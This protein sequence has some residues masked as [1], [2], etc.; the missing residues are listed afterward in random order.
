MRKAA[1]YVAI[2]MSIAVLFLATSGATTAYAGGGN[3]GSPPGN[4]GVVKVISDPGDS[5]NDPDNDPHVCL[6]HLYGFNFDANSSGTWHIDPW[7]PDGGPLTAEQRDGTWKAFKGGDKSKDWQFNAYPRQP[8]P[9]GH[10][11]LTVKQTNGMTPGGDN[12]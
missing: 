6:F 11:K 8:F 3:G 4:N 12:S 5:Q 2:L 10:Y 9:N 7:P 1:G